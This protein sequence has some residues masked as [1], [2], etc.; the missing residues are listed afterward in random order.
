[1]VRR[2]VS[3]FP[4]SDGVARDPARTG[5]LPGRVDEKKLFGGYFEDLA[6]GRGW[7]GARLATALTGETDPV[8]QDMVS[9]S[10]FLRLMRKVISP[11]SSGE[12]DLRFFASHLLL[13]PPFYDKMFGNGHSYCTFR[14]AAERF[15]DVVRNFSRRRSPTWSFSTHWR[16]ARSLGG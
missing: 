9:D 11:G 5:W 13:Y 7:D 3:L 12:V 4:R 6:K 1:M 15:W 10:R 16:A 2:P 14:E 8:R